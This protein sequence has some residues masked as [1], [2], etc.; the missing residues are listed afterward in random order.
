ML[1]SA[2][3]HRSPLADR[4][5]RFDEGSGPGSIAQ[6]SFGKVYAALDTVSQE[7]VAVKRQMLPSDAAA[8]ELAWYKALGPV[9]HP[10]LMCLR[11]HFVFGRGGGRWMYMVFDFMDTNL[12]TYWSQRRRVIPMPIVV[13]LIR[14]LAGALGHLHF[15]GIVHADLS[16]ANMLLQCASVAAPSQDTST[17]VLRVAD[18]GGAVNAG[19]V[20]LPAQK[21]ITTEYARA[22]EVIMGERSLTATIDL[23]ALGITCMALVCGSLVFYRI[24][25]V[26]PIVLGLENTDSDDHV[27]PEHHVLGIRTLRNQV[28]VLGPITSAIYPRCG[29]LPHWQQVYDV[30]SGRA[31]RERSCDFFA[32]AVYVRRPVAVDDVASSFMLSLLC[33]NPGDRLGA[34]ECQEHA[35]LN[36]RGVCSAAGRGIVERLSLPQ[37]RDVVMQSMR[38]DRPISFEAILEMAMAQPAPVIHEAVV[39]QSAEEEVN[40]TLA[41]PGSICSTLA[42]SHCGAREGGSSSIASQVKRIRLTEKSPRPASYLLVAD[43]AAGPSMGCVS[44]SANHAG[45]SAGSDA[46]PAGSLCSGASSQD[47]ASAAASSPPRCACKGNCAL[48]ACKANKNYFTRGVR[49]ESW[50][51]SR[52][53]SPG[54]RYCGFCACEACR[55]GCRQ[56]CHGDCRWCSTCWK[57]F[58]TVVS[59]S[60][61][62]Y[63]NMYGSF[64]V[65]PVWP[66]ALQWAAIYAWTSGVAPG[67]EAAFYDNFVLRFLRWRGLGSIT[68]VTHGGDVML[69][70]MIGCVR[71]PVLVFRCLD[72][73]E[74]FEPR[75]A[76][77]SEW[78]EYIQRLVRFADGKLWKPMFD[79]ISPGRSRCVFGL[80][81]MAKRFGV[82]RKYDGKDATVRTVAIGVSQTRY[83]LS[84]PAASHN[85]LQ[86]I[87]DGVAANAFRFPHG[88]CGKEDRD[89]FL[90]SVSAIVDFFVGPQS[91]L[92]RGYCSLKLLSALQKHHGPHLWDDVSMLSL[93]ALVPDENKY[94]Q[95]LNGWTG[96]DVRQRFGMSP[97]SVAGM[98]CF[99][100]TVPSHQ[101][102]A[103]RSRDNKDIMN[104]VAG[105]GAEEPMAECVRLAQK[106]GDTLEYAVSPNVWVAHLVG[107]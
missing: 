46:A 26:E 39:V 52:P 83:V 87:I 32:D 27:A 4:Y 98:A 41:E 19:S 45:A 82:M 21:V 67:V 91:K 62:S 3:S 105:G 14:N 65:S 20:M 1:G 11:D 57:S 7:T 73:L 9:G 94:L 66:P 74:G 70:I 31:L 43:I 106:A 89:D 68:E 24:D 13:S 51:C 29:D 88:F 36:D 38:Q 40:K 60:H 56:Q 72:L 30:V 37:L 100:G 63:R 90:R 8:K 99:W 33:W 15:L 81:W 54:S 35:F 71:W 16:M 104:A 12:W 86:S 107:A 80:A 69:L 47:S 48:R 76:T 93:S 77:A 23:W 92:A 61:M 10:H 95:C 84:S 58:G 17:M 28:A 25:G 18:F 5:K 55:V 42:L 78:H 101:M 97:I 49:V 2:S 44:A 50:F 85:A 59:E 96:A 75:T 53:S 79:L 34:K 22:P 64:R 6:G 102:I 103:L